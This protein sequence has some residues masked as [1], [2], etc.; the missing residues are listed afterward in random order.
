VPEQAECPFSRAGID[1]IADESDPVGA[2]ALAGQ[3]HVQ[4]SISGPNISHSSKS[5]FSRGREVGPPLEDGSPDGIVWP[6]RVFWKPRAWAF[7][8]GGGMTPRRETGWS[9]CRASFVRGVAQR[10]ACSF[11]GRLFPKN[12]SSDAS[13]ERQGL[14]LG[15]AQRA[16]HW[17]ARL[18]RVASA[19][20]FVL[21][22]LAILA[23]SVVSDSAYIPESA[24]DGVG[25]L[26]P[27]PGE[28]PPP[29]AAMRRTNVGR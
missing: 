14:A 6:G 27:V 28:A 3:T 22:C 26:S 13:P 29:I 11:S 9:A 8:W 15:V 24:T 7:R 12:V 2:V 5:G 17:L 16:D 4:S 19:L 23:A 25:H 1:G 20:S 21:P 10:R 18:A